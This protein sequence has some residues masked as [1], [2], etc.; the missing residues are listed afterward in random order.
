MRVPDSALLE[1][2][3]SKQQCS[4]ADQHVQTGTESDYQLSGML[5]VH[6]LCT[7]DM[8]NDW[9][10]YH[11]GRLESKVLLFRAKSA[12]QRSPN[13][14]QDSKVDAQTTH[15]SQLMIVSGL[16]GETEVLINS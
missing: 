5:V 7:H 6:Y 3:T 12:S 9:L 2:G 4:W 1:F 15:V 16:L 13:E 10:H 11:T 8:G 14:E